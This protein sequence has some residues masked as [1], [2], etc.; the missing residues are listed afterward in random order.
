MHRHCASTDCNCAKLLSQLISNQRRNDGNEVIRQAL[1]NS[2]LLGAFPSPTPQIA[3]WSNHHAPTTRNELSALN[4]AL[5]CCILWRGWM[6]L[7]IMVMVI[8][9]NSSNLGQ[10]LHLNWSLHYKCTYYLSLPPRVLYPKVP[11]VVSGL[12]AGGCGCSSCAEL[13]HCWSVGSATCC[14]G[15]SREDIPR[16]RLCDVAPL[17]YCAFYPQTRFSYRQIFWYLYEAPN[18]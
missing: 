10:S 11:D 15:S 16:V 4:N 12:Q 5:F 18:E 7:V 13:H 9:V 1:R 17:R 14:P 8:F 3:D 6:T 2:K